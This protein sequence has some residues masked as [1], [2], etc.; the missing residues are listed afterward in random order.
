MRFEVGG[1]SADLL[2]DIEQFELSIAEFFPDARTGEV[3]R[4]R[5]LLEPDHADVGREV[6]LLAIQ[7]FVLHAPHATILI[8]TCVGEGK[9][10]PL[11]PEW[12]H[13][14]G[15]GY[16]DRLARI[17][18][19][20]E[21]VDLVVCT[22]LHLDHVGWNTRADDGRW[23]PTFPNARCLIGRRELA[24]WEDERR[25]SDKLAPLHLC[26]VEDSVLPILESGQAELVDDG[27]ELGR[28]MT[29][30]PL[31][32]HTPGQMGLQVDGPGEHTVLRRRDPQPP[33]G[34]RHQPLDLVMCGSRTGSPGTSCRARGRSRARPT[35]RAGALSRL[36]ADDRPGHG[37]WFHALLPRLTLLQRSSVDYARRPGM[38]SGEK[39]VAVIDVTK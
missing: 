4:S 17:G 19:R 28:G 20:P 24:F 36:A 29:L 26:A 32:G 23:V 7:S 10:R 13:R 38:V 1:F 39:L 37:D 11:I 31:P 6:L 12:D 27:Y 5:T 30:M 18:V 21:S 34:A 35:D 25:D 33:A 8:D 3:E 16:L 2:V 9:A 15:G 22:H 14:S